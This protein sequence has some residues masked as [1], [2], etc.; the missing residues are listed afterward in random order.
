MGAI[1]LLS[2]VFSTSLLANSSSDRLAC[3]KANKLI[4]SELTLGGLHH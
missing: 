4:P 2:F 1:L 3:Y